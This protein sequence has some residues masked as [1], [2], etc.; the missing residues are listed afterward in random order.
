M[1][2]NAAYWA[3]SVATA[4]L[5]PPNGVGMIVADVAMIAAADKVDMPVFLN[6]G[7]RVAS[8][9]M[10]RLDALGITRDNKFPSK[11]TTGTRT[12]TD[13]IFPRGFVMTLTVTS[14]ALM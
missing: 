14:F 4:T 10:A 1:F 13:L 2:A 11:N 8:K 9:I 5:S 3:S 12:Y 6:T 7:N